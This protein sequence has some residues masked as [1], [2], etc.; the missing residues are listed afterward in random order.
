MRTVKTIIDILGGLE[1]LKKTAIRIENPPFMV[2]CIEYI[3]NGPRNMPMVSVAH[4]GEQNGDLMRDPDMVFEVGD[5][6]F[7]IP[8]TTVGCM[9]NWGPI[10][11][12][13]DYAGL[14]QEAVWEDEGGRV[15]V[16]PRLVVELRR[17]ATTWDVNIHDQGFL[18]AAT[19][20]RGETL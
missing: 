9:K 13:N 20:A 16:K 3:G 19:H 14:D 15:L 7:D 2:L 5:P 17:F 8:K 1:A 10:S 11:Y 12:R 6:A 18:E 4:Y